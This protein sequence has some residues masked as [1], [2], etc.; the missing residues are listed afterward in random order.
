MMTQ[1]KKQTP[2]QKIKN[3][4]KDFVTK[5]NPVFGN[6]PP[7]PFA[8]KAIVDGKVK[9]IELDGLGEFGTIFT[10]VW[11]FDFDKKDVLILIAEPDQYTAKQ[12]VEIADMLNWA[13]MPRDVVILEDHPEISESVKRVKLNNGEYILF[14][15]QRLSK[16]NRY[17]EM[18][19]KGP[20]YKNWSK[21][22][23][24]SVKGFR[25]NQNQ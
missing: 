25:E 2:T 21:S 14:L 1:P 13:F 18:L 4:I 20:Y 5:P 10:H 15:A 6:L 11:D 19:E 17:S 12:T 9:F 7:C 22:Y 24:Q 23:L 8:Q 3:W 16:L